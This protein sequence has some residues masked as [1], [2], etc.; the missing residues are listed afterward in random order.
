MQ[1]TFLLL[2]VRSS[3]PNAINRS[4]NGRCNCLSEHLRLL[5]NAY[6]LEGRL[7][8]EYSVDVGDYAAEFDWLSFE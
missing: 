2:L 6:L 4:H 3:P 1:R 8:S 5:V 7:V